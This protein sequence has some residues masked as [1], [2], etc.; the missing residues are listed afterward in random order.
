ME[1][2]EVSDEHC[3]V[4]SCPYVI[5]LFYCFVLLLAGFSS[6][7]SC[8]HIYLSNEYIFVL[9]T[10][11]LEDLSHDHANLRKKVP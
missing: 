1:G 7:Y 3:L 8:M 4:W 6:N 10:V 11:D 5:Y 9:E 2:G